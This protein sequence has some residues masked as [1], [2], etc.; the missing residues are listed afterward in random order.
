[1]SFP[2]VITPLQGSPGD[3]SKPIH[4]PPGVWPNP[5][6]GGGLPPGW[7]TKPP[8]DIVWPPQLPPLPPGVVKPP[9]DLP[10]NIPAFP[11]VIPEPPG[12]PPIVMPPIALPPTIWPPVDPSAGLPPSG[13]SL[14]LVWISG[15]GWRWLL[16]DLSQPKK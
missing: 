9:I 7:W 14:V 13:R 4:L 15:V 2:A 11:I 12:G 6:G 16:V 5:P 10:P 8:A 1:M 3:P